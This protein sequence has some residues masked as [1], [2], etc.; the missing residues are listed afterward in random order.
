MKLADQAALHST[1]VLPSHREP[2]CH[3]DSRVI[4]ERCAVVPV[5]HA[6]T[7]IHGHPEVAPEERVEEFDIVALET[8]PSI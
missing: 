4:D 5:S 3:A 8:V 6:N 7:V 2:R 1:R